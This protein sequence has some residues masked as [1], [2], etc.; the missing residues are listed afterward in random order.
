MLDAGAGRDM[1]APR[2]GGAEMARMYQP[3]FDS[4]HV[5]PYE[6]GIDAIEPE[7]IAAALARHGERFLERI[8][9]PAERVICR[10]RVNSLAA[11]FAAKEAVAKALGTGL[12]TIAW[13]EVEILANE[14]GRPVLVLHGAAAARAAHLGLQHWSVSLTHLNGLALAMVIAS[15]GTGPQGRE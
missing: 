6:A 2:A 11:R 15:A 9:T 8:F 14:R 10:G 4:D 1:V 7:R 3:S 13:R 5:G 12:G